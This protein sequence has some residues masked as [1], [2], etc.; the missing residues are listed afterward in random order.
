[1]NN[2]EALT[3]FMTS[4]PVKNPEKWMLLLFPLITLAV[5]LAGIMAF[6]MVTRW[7]APLF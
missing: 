5:F 4:K 7:I 2:Q 6:H 1:L 3:A